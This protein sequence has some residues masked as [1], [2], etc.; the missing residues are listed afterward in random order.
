MVLDGI[1]VCALTS[2]SHRT[3]ENPGI[4]RLR[5]AGHSMSAAG[6]T[7][8]GER[9]NCGRERGGGGVSTSIAAASAS[10]AAASALRKQ[11]SD[12]A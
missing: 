9:K 6:A 10:I 1:R 8:G 7:D 12:W 4:G 5:A 11:T 2:I 3:K